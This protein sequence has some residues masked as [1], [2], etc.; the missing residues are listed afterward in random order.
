MS[1]ILL[2]YNFCSNKLIVFDET[3]LCRPKSLETFSIKT[4]W[5]KNSRNTNLGENKTVTAVAD[6]EP[7][8]TTRDPTVTQ[9]ASEDDEDKTTG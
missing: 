5:K 3:T 8:A 6:E 2:L 1:K 9:A 7:L 4:F